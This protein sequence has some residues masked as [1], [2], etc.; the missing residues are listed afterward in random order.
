MPEPYEEDPDDR[1]ND[2]DGAENQWEFRCYRRLEL[3]VSD[4]HGGDRGHCIGLKEI[5][6][7]AGTIP[8]VIAHVIGD[9]SRVPRIILRDACLD[10][11]DQVGS[12]IG[13][14]GEDAA[15][16][17]RED[18]YETAAETERNQRKYVT[19][20]CIVTRGDGQCQTGDDQTGD[21]SPLKGH[22]QSGG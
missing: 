2:G 22:G 7:H 3:Q 9:G 1:R 8:D 16:E 19:G 11:S 18:G 15:T 20:E 13:A 4:E 5:G 14:L 21:R 10:L 12:H 6:S 17:A